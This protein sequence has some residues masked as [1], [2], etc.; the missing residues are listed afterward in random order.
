VAGS[1]SISIW[2]DEVKQGDG[3]AARCLWDRYFPDLVRLA[4]RKLDGMPQKMEDEED[5]A[6]SVF[7]TFCRAAER[8]RYPDLNSRESLWRLLCRITHDKAVDAIRRSRKGMGDARVQGESYLTGN[9]TSMHGRMVPVAKPETEADFA[10]IVA[11]EV[12]RLLTMLPSEELRSIAMAKMEN[13][14]NGEIA[15]KIGCA[16]RTVERRLNYIRAIWKEEFPSAD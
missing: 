15:E 2:L 3:D 13:Y 12:R 6:L 5:V 4:R 14:T 1:N 10:V 7:H 9:G 8:G 16:V 11:D